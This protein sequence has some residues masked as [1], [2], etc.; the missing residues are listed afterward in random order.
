MHEARNFIALLMLLAAFTVRADIQVPS[1]ATY[2]VH[3]YCTGV[4]P[5]TPFGLDFVN[6]WTR[7]D[8]ERAS[9]WDEQEDREKQWSIYFRVARIAA[10][11]FY[12]ACRNVNAYEGELNADPVFTGLAKVISVRRGGG[13]WDGNWKHGDDNLDRMIDVGVLESCYWANLTK[14]GKSSGAANV[15]SL[16]KRVVSE[17]CTAGTRLRT[18]IGIFPNQDA[19]DVLLLTHCAVATPTSDAA[20]PLLLERDALLVSLRSQMSNGG[21]IRYIGNENDVPVY[22]GITTSF[23]LRSNQIIPSPSIGEIIRKSAVYWGRVY[24]GTPLVEYWSAPWWKQFWSPQPSAPLISEYLFTCDKLLRTHLGALY[25]HLSKDPVGIETIVAAIE[26]GVRRSC[27]A[28]EEG[29]APQVSS[30]FHIIKDEDIGGFRASNSF[31]AFGIN[32]RGSA[33]DTYVGATFFGSRDQA[34]SP[35][36]ITG[37]R[38]AMQGPNNTMYR[39]GGEPSLTVASFSG[40]RLSVSVSYQYIKDPRPGW[41]QYVAPL[42]MRSATQHW[43]VSQHRIQGRLEAASPSDG[44]QALELDWIGPAEKL[45]RL[46]GGASFVL[47]GSTVAVSAIRAESCEVSLADGPASFGRLK[48]FSRLAVKCKAR[49]PSNPVTFLLSIS[50]PED[51]KQWIGNR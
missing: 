37:V 15:R 35:V 29:H 24:R 11:L 30:R 46:A 12:V 41:P 33:H 47:S 50:M 49:N 3:Q 2:Y 48:A 26:W 13:W 9:R 28:D 39:Y 20:G 17:I 5:E 36:A 8:F 14:T 45:E 7:G 22:H 10:A 42:E 44:E 23:L 27:P 32:G 21:A 34:Q 31:F 18:N 40:D 16:C 4:S 51:E 25:A 43:D 6:R 19:A 38:L 1:A